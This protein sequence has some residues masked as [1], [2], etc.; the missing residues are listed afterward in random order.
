MLYMIDYLRKYKLLIAFIIVLIITLKVSGQTTPLYNAY[1]RSVL[2]G[3]NNDI[4]NANNL[5]FN[6]VAVGNGA[7]SNSWQGNFIGIGNVGTSSNFIAGSL[8]HGCV[9]VGGVSNS[10]PG[11]AYTTIV[12]GNNNTNDDFVGSFIGGGG[13][14]YITGLPFA[15][16]VV[17]GGYN[18]HNGSDYSFIGGGRSNSVG[19]GYFLINLGGTANLIDLGT[20]TASLGGGAILGGISNYLT[21]YRSF[22]IGNWLSNTTPDTIDIGVGNSTKTTIGSSSVLFRVP[23]SY[24]ATPTSIVA[25]DATVI[26]NISYSG[27]I[28]SFTV[29][30]GLAKTINASQATNIFT[31]TYPVTYSTT[32]K[33]VILPYNQNASIWVW[34]IGSLYPT[35]M[36]TS[37]AVICC[38][39]NQSAAVGTYPN[40]TFLI[41]L[42]L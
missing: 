23:V 13:N 42:E 29:N 17:G 21:G 31:I 34:N 6:G 30:F 20:P 28:H 40:M 36:S 2:N 25:A 38:Y 41:D 32:P 16:V 11:G 10:I 14:N 5:I 12:G 22:A 35:N 19:Q 15:D 4:T 3:N 18:S 1:L 9:I 26:T 27:N 37:S 33:L 7:V 24:G 8:T 39:L